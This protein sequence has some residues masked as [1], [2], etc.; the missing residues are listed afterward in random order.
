M[1]VCVCVCVRVRVRMRVCVC[2]VGRA[3]GVSIGREGKARMGKRQRIYERH[4]SKRKRIEGRDRRGKRGK[5]TVGRGKGKGKGRGRG[6]G[7][8]RE[9]EMYP[10]GIRGTK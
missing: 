10:T 4:T 5:W 6:R 2:G 1:C 8:E 7:R 9:G 3:F